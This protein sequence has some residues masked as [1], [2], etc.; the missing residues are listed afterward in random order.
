M[1]K[2]IFLSGVGGMLGEAFYKIFS[3]KY[4]LKCTDKDVNENWLEYLDFCNSENYKLLVEKF[5]PNYLFHI[6]AFTDLE[7]CE[8]NQSET[9]RTNTESVKTAVAISNN[10]NIPLLYVSTAGIFDG[11]KEFYDE[12]DIPKPMGVYAVS[13]YEAEKFVVENCKK[14]LI[15]RAGWMMGGGPKKDK[16]F[17]QKIIKQI[18]DGKKELFIVDDKFGTPTYT[19][20]FAKNTEALIATNNFGLYNMACEGNTSRY[21]VSEEILKILNLENSIRLTKVNSDY[22]SK[23]FFAKRPNSENLLNKK[24]N[25]IGLNLMRPWQ[26]TLKEYLENSYSTYL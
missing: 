10:L 18:K 7:F 13:K 24:L 16:K 17:I 25:T 8:K 6:G 19:Y 20:D 22:F 15:C 3:K 1:N 21:E 26:V 9:F 23:T 5:S 11:L 4:K 14:Y 12:N 2:K